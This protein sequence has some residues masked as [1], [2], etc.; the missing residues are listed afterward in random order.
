MNGGTR[1]I[2]MLRRRLCSVSRSNVGYGAP[3]GSGAGVRAVGR[4][5]GPSERRRIRGVRHAVPS[6]SSGELRLPDGTCRSNRHKLASPRTISA[7]RMQDSDWRADRRAEVARGDSRS[8]DSN[9]TRWSGS[10]FAAPQQPYPPCVTMD[11]FIPSNRARNCMRHRRAFRCMEIMT[12][13]RLDV[14]QSD[15]LLLDL[16]RTL[17]FQRAR[18]H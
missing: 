5:D 14:Q 15:C 2:R 1:C 3:C 16:T 6:S 4:L 7:G 18:C 17:E 11:E 8:E 9:R 13:L 12:H 10:P